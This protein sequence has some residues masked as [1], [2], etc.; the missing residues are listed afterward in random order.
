MDQA[1]IRYHCVQKVIFPG[2][3]EVHNIWICSV[4]R[5]C[6]GLLKTITFSCQGKLVLVQ[7]ASLMLSSDQQRSSHSN[8]PNVLRELHL[9][10]VYQQEQAGKLN[11]FSTI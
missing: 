11:H 1:L 6:Y 4:N 2:S 3:I 5:E 9:S 8:S 7:K 10:V